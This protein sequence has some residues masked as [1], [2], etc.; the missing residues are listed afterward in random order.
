M[1]AAQLGRPNKIPS[2]KWIQVHL[3]LC[4][5]TSFAVSSQSGYSTAK[6]LIA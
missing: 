5:G 6:L 2:L 1:M 3:S 4:E